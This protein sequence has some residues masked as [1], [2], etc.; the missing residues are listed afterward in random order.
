MSAL[1]LAIRSESMAA[2]R[3]RNAHHPLRAAAWRTIEL[4][5]IHTR[6]RLSSLVLH[7]GEQAHRHTTGRPVP[8]ITHPDTRLRSWHD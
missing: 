8:R 5:A 1:H 2:N 3:D 7:A 4:A 6:R